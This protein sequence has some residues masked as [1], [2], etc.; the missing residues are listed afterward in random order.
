MTDLQKLL[1]VVILAMASWGLV[2]G[3]FIIAIEALAVGF[4][5]EC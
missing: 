5:V 4:G 2:F 3:G 1:L